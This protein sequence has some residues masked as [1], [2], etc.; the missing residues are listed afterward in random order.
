MFQDEARF[1]LLSNPS[2][3]WAP[4]GVRP[5]VAKQQIR[6]YIYAYGA[7]DPVSGESEFLILPNMETVCMNIFLRELANK[8]PGER[9]VLFCDQA[10]SHIS[11]DLKVP[12]NIA[13]HHIPPYS[14]QVNPS[15]N[16]WKV[17]KPD[18]FSNIIFSSFDALEDRLC[19]V[20]AALE[21]SKHLIRSVAGFPWIIANS[22]PF[23]NEVPSC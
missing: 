14:P 8:Y 2:R 15:E 18:V 23:M 12:R 16:V 21:K 13:L 9:I 19:D 6:E 3:C 10:S 7:V 17:V 11:K 22:L 5:E 20:L 1:G 4:Q